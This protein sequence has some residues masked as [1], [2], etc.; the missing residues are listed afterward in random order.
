MVNFALEGSQKS[1]LKVKKCCG[2][3]LVFQNEATSIARQD[4]VMNNISCK[5]E[6]CSYSIFF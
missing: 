3:H 6:K 4:F 2:D 5:F 1:L